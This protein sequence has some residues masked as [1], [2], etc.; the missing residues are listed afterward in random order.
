MQTSKIIH[1]TLIMKFV[2]TSSVH[3]QLIIIFSRNPEVTIS[4]NK[5][6]RLQYCRSP[7][8]LRRCPVWSC[9]DSIIW[10]PLR[11]LAKLLPDLILGIQNTAYF[12][13]IGI[14]SKWI[15]IRF[16]LLSPCPTST[17]WPMDRA[18]VEETAGAL[19][20][21]SLCCF[22]VMFFL[23]FLYINTHMFSHKLYR[24]ITH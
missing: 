23:I 4:L 22:L 13:E 18:C 20:T 1:Q 9:Q 6:T 8:K 5:P 15:H 19:S 14:Q 17:A 11:L 2:F 7:C 3:P 16:F 21:T 10:S 24:V 12:Q